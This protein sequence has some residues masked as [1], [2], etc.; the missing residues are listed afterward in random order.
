MIL[1]SQGRGTKSYV[2]FLIR[3][4]N[5]N[6][7]VNFQLVYNKARVRVLRRCDIIGLTMET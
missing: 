6:F 4:S 2:L 3:A 7:M 1:T 5:S